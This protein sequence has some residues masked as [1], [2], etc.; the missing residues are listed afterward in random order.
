MRAHSD[1]GQRTVRLAAAVLIAAFAALAAGCQSA[2]S[3][4]TGIPAVPNPGNGQM[5]D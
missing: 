4:H 5:G 3:Y 2:N 1:K